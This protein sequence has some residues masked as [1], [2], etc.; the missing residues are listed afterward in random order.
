MLKEYR[1]VMDGIWRAMIK[2]SCLMNIKARKKQIKIFTSFFE[3]VGKSKV[4]VN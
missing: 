4:L 3:D 1:I 2:F